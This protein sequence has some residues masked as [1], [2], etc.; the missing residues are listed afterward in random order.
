MDAHSQ[1]MSVL[2]TL[3]SFSWEAKLVL[4]LFAVALNYGKYLLLAEV[5][6]SDKLPEPMAILKGMAD[7]R[8]HSDMLKSRFS[9]LNNLIIPMLDL[10]K[11]IVEFTELLPMSSSIDVKAF[12]IATDIAT[13]AISSATYW[14]IRGALACASNI[15]QLNS[16]GLE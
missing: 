2:N 3:S 12:S 1:T 5:Y 10:A 8:E 9:Q 13:D 15:A 4:T 6:L 14:N 11:C 16:M 7:I